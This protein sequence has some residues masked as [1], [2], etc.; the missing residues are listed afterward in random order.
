[1]R[2]RNATF[3]EVTRTY[4]RELVI[5]F[6]YYLHREESQTCQLFHRGTFLLD[7]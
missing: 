1:M 5:I 6:S 2:N 7:M 4:D 3:N